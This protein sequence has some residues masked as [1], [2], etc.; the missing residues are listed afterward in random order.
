M[1]FLAIGA[2]AQV[3]GTQATRQAE[4][5]AACQVVGAESVHFLN[6]GDGES[7][8][9]LPLK[10]DMVRVLRTVQP[11]V[12]VARDP[13]AF[14]V[15]DTVIN[16]TDHRTSGACRHVSGHRSKP[17]IPALSPVSTVA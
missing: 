3:P 16:H 7:E 17:C 11:D 8:A 4:R 1:R 12:G 9:G 14:W 15:G 10:R 2:P 5:R 13:T 6:Y